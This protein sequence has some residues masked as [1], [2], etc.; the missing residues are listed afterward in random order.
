M[1]EDE[2]RT[3]FQYRYDIVS[4][5]VSSPIDPEERCE[6]VQGAVEKKVIRDDRIKG[7]NSSI[8]AE[9][10]IPCNGRTGLYVEPLER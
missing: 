3:F 6:E 10:P 7:K 5:L 1:R 2:Q 9:W 8:L 4:N